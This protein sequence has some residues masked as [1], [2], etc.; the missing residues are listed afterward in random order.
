MSFFSFS[1][2]DD[3]FFVMKLEMVRQQLILLVAFLSLSS[4]SL[5]QETIE[6]GLTK[7][8]GTHKFV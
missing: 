2:L 4:L 5:C 7:K 6:N 8:E 3:N 1:L